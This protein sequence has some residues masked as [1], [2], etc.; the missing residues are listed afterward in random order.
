LLNVAQG[1]SPASQWQSP[2]CRQAGKALH[3]KSAPKL[4]YVQSYV[5]VIELKMT[6]NKYLGILQPT[7]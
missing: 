7:G 1:F 3:Y 6:N 5:Q 2:A 4:R